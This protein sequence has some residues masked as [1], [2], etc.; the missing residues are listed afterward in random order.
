MKAVSPLMVAVAAVALL[1]TFRDPGGAAPKTHLMV[2]AGAASKPPSLEAKAAY[3]K[4]HPDVQIDI[5]FG[6]SGTILQQMMLEEVGDIYMPGSDDFMDKAEEK[7]AVIPQTRKIVC[8]LVPTICVQHG[9]PKKIRSLTDLARPGITVGLAK[10]GAVCLGDASEAVLTKA[11]LLE[12]V[13]KNVITYAASCEHTQQ[14][15]QL[16]EVDAVIGWDAFKSWA[17]DQIDLVK[18]DPKY[19][20]V[21]NIPAAVAV[22]S[23]QRPAAERFIAFLTSKQGKAIFA[24]HGYSIEPPKLQ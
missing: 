21:H 2:F 23:Q 24:K 13:K 6:G 4:A 10:P 18:I 15:V 16:G 7:K 17:P 20:R 9:N 3:E 8:Y 1:A 22:Y 5:T 11:G 19:L 12:K 14:L